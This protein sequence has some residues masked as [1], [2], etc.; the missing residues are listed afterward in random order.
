MVC[1]GIPGGSGIIKKAKGY[2]GFVARTNAQTIKEGAKIASKAVNATPILGTAANVA[3]KAGM[4]T[5]EAI[6]LLNEQEQQPKP[7]KSRPQSAP[8]AQDVGN[9][10]PEVNVTGSKSYSELGWN[11]T[12]GLLEE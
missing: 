1:D 11:S 10:L 4:S 3:A 7:A 5:A 2:I 12:A 8:T 6:K 9:T